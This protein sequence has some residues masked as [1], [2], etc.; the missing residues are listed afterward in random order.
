MNEFLE[1]FIIIVVFLV[2]ILLSLKAADFWFNTK[3]ETLKEPVHKSKL[4]F[5]YYGNFFIK[6]IILCIALGFVALLTEKVLR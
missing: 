4:L 6:F 3:V 1:V 2:W 5:W